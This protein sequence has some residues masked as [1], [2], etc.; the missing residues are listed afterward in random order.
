MFDFWN[1]L[2]ITKNIK[3]FLVVQ[4]EKDRG[5]ETEREREGEKGRG[6][7]EWGTLVAIYLS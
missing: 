4:R 5:R 6:G 2:R 1:F 3:I 7:R